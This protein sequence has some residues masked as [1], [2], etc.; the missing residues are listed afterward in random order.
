MTAIASLVR[1]ATTSRFLRFCVV[2]TIGFAIDASTFYLLHDVAGLSPYAARAFSILISMTCTWFGNRSLTFR[3]HAAT[4][5]RAIL[6]E[7]LTFAGTNA[8]GAMANYS[9]FAALIAF[10]PYPFSYRYFALAAGTGVGLVF[11][12]TLSQRIVF[13]PRDTAT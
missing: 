13:R 10:A 4:G 8:I 11:N 1:A 3:D 5:P 9:T 6:R 7:Y 2:G 12:F